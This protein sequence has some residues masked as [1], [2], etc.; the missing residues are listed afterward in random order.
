M[1]TKPLVSG[2]AQAFR[3]DRTTVIN[4]G[5]RWFFR[6]ARPLL[7]SVSLC[8]VA[9]TAQ[10]PGHRCRKND[11]MYL[12]A[13]QLLVHGSNPAPEFEPAKR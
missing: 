7:G 1:E 11:L 10:A 3:P 4:Q 12:G 8:L 2:L 5:S 9:S 6:H 13:T